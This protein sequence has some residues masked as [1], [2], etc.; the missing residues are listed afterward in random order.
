[1]IAT[2]TTY[3]HVSTQAKKKNPHH[4]KTSTCPNVVVEMQSNSFSLLRR[5]LRG[6][7]MSRFLLFTVQ[8]PKKAAAS[9]APAAVLP[10]INIH[11]PRGKISFDTDS[12]SSRTPTPVKGYSGTTPVVAML[13]P[14]TA[15]DADSPATVTAQSPLKHQLQP[16]LPAD[17]L[18]APEPPAPR[19][20]PIPTPPRR[21]DANPRDSVAES[22]RASIAS[23]LGESASRSSIA[24]YSVDEEEGDDGASSSDDSAISYWSSDSEY[25]ASPAVSALS[26]EKE[27]DKE[28]RM[29]EAAEAEAELEAQRRR[30]EHRK[31]VLED[32]GL[33]IRHE[34]AA[35]VLDNRRRVVRRRRAPAVPAGGRR[36]KPNTPDTA[37]LLTPKAPAAGDED[38]DSDVPPPTPAKSTADQVQD[39]YAKYE[40]YLAE[41]AE[42]PSAAAT[43]T[44]GAPGPEVKTTVELPS[45]SAKREVSGGS[46]GSRGSNLAH[47]LNMGAATTK[48]TGFLSRMGNAGAHAERAPKAGL[49]ISGP[50]GGAP[51][52]PP[53]P[54]PDSMVSEA[55]SQSHNHKELVSSGTPAAP[56]IPDYAFGHTWSSLVDPSVLETMEKQER[57]RQEAIFEFIATE[58]TYVRNLQLVVG[59]FYA[60]LMNILD[61]HALTVIFA[62]VEDIM[63]FNSFF[64]SALE[65]RQKSCRL[66][67]THLG[68]ILS[69]HCQNLEVYLPY[70]LNQDSARRLLVELRK[71]NPEL[72]AALQ[73]I[74]M[75]N[76]EVRGLDLSSFL[77]EPMQRLTRYPLLLKQIVQYTTAEQDLEEVKR[78]LAYVET[79]VSD[80]NESVRQRENK[81][82]LK[83]L[84][85][86]VW[87]SSDK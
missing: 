55:S 72:E 15:T 59:V 65:E 54:R 64:L 30:R 73:D 18:L 8:L 17:E 3:L 36:S 11:I 19:K 13:S 20:R 84:S 60:R 58:A 10:F 26:P 71:S 5:G 12:D 52:G 66:Y 62:N 28:R 79:T 9:V 2:S 24:Q 85:D 57:K 7:L 80:V 44:V 86:E 51:I 27:V 38:A 42:R 16:Q 82:R 4:P 33:Q 39:A 53:S 69:E 81:D 32:V 23:S 25:D 78:A 29:K 1:M 37:R 50:V 41:M 83:E 6:N 47:H 35:L 87:I 43:K 49:T 34:D 22:N 56:A 75:N 45:H 61:E 70:C 40:Q 31:M 48:I 14:S 67:V 74:K 76:P 77:L 68:D 63:M 21:G 46:G